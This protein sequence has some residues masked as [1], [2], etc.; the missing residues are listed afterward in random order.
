[1]VFFLIFAVQVI[2]LKNTVKE[3]R[4][5]LYAYRKGKKAV[6]PYFVFY[7]ANTESGGNRLGITVSKAIGKAH[8]RNRAKRLIREAYRLNLAGKIPQ[9]HN[10]VIVA[11]ERIGEA[12]FEKLCGSM[13]YAAYQTELLEKTTDTDGGEA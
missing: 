4:E 3:N 9:S 6:T 13:R 11:R 2:I 12:P 8:D 7:C 10:I 1:M 5:F